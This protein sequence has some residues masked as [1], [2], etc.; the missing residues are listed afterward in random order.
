MGTRAGG[1]VSRLRAE[2]GAAF[3]EP[4]LTDAVIAHRANHPASSLMPL[5]GQ[6]LR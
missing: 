4:D 5:E 6:P 1:S 3:E 2:V